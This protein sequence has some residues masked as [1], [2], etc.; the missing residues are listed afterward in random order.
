MKIL[1]ITHSMEKNGKEIRVTQLCYR[2]KFIGRHDE[3]EC[4]GFI[5]QV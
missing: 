2:I 1:A 5:E 4:P 3:P